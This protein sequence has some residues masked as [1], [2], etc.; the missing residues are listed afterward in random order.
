MILANPKKQ[1]TRP[2]A[3]EVNHRFRIPRPCDTVLAST[4]LH[5]CGGEVD[6]GRHYR[7]RA[8]RPPDL[9]VSDRV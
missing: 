3:P 2:A 8:N 5:L 4:A 1:L 9:R 6:V 7:F